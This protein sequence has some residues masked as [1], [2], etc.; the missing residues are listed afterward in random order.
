MK[1]ATS[2]CKRIRRRLKHLE[3]FE[4]NFPCSLVKETTPLGKF[5]V[6]P[7]S[8]YVSYKSF[9]KS[10]KAFLIAITFSDDLKSF[11]YAV[12]YTNW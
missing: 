7:L 3:D 8:H 1:F 10:H 4:T 11:P 9:S 12:K 5:M 6:Y 2:P